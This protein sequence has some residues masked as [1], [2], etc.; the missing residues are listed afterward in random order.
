MFLI[1]GVDSWTSPLGQSIY[2]FVIITQTRQQYIYSINN[3]SSDRHTAKFNEEKIL[4]VIEKIGVNK[5]VT[6]VTDAEAAL[7]AAKREVIKKHPH[8]MAVRCIA[9][10]I[11]LITKDIISIE[12]AKNTLQKCQQIVSFFHNAHRAGEAL[13][14]EIISSFSIRGNLKSAVKTRWST[15]W[16]VCESILH[17][18]NSVKLVSIFFKKK[19][20]IY[21]INIF[22][23][24]N[25][26]LKKTLV[27]LQ[28]LKQLKLLFKTDNFGMMLSN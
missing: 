22:Y 20:L 25:R 10:H 14:N 23:L 2:A 17:L 11:N 15:V 6:I 18:E 5:F 13:R 28:L 24:I 16:D 7:K 8:I 27:F 21:I 9:H 1:L 19:F 4:N 3:F 12:W 26:F